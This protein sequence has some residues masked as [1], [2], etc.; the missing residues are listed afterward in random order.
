M[1]E[2]NMEV[3]GVEK[4]GNVE[5][6][7][8]QEDL[9]NGSCSDHMH[10]FDKDIVLPETSF[11]TEVIECLSRNGYCFIS[12]LGS[13]GGIITYSDIQKPPVRMWLFGMIT[14]VEMYIDS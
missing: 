5:G 3:V 2:N 7:V 14:I 10:C 6:F 9:T 11:Y 13:V 1:V 12:I 8:Q 4:G